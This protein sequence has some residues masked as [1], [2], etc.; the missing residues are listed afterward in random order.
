MY[1]KSNFISSIS[2]V[3]GFTGILWK[4]GSEAIID[5]AYELVEKWEDELDMATS[6]YTQ[7]KIKEELYFLINNAARKGLCVIK[8]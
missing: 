5:E 4:K 7:E 1:Q 8:A 3:L 6:P 2:C